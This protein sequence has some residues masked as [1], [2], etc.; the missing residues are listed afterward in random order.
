MQCACAFTASPHR[1]A[2]STAP[3]LA[4]S[5]LPLQVTTPQGGAAT[6]ASKGGKGTPEGSGS[7]SMMD[8]LENTLWNRSLGAMSEEIVAALVCQIF[9]GERRA[10]GRGLLCNL[11]RGQEAFPSKFLPA[12]QPA[13]QPAARCNAHVPPPIHPRPQSPL[14]LSHHCPPAGI[15]DH[16]VQSVELKFNCFFLMPMID[17][18]PNKLREELEQAYEED[19]DE[20]RGRG[21]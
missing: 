6:A 7:S 14:P 19:L 13:R 18:F 15:R 4:W 17:I 21:W 2:L 9:E 5:P 8:M 3:W 12:W 10:S 16:Y 11:G 20:V 1:N